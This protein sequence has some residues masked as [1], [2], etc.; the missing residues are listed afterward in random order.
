MK[1]D[2]DLQARL[3]EALK[4]AIN[5]GFNNKSTK[6]QLIENLHDITAKTV[7]DY[8]NGAVGKKA[9]SIRGFSPRMQ[10]STNHI[11]VSNDDFNTITSKL[12]PIYSAIE[13]LAESVNQ[14]RIIITLK[15]IDIYARTATSAI[16]KA[17]G[18]FM[19]SLVDAI[20]SNAKKEFKELEQ[21]GSGALKKG[22]FLE[23]FFGEMS[24]AEMQSKALD[25]APVEKFT[26]AL[27]NLIEP[28]AAAAANLVEAANK[29]TQRRQAEKVQQQR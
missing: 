29:E 18:E 19:S 20:T 10:A 26:K 25:E 12:N 16:M 28:I 27:D 21:S 17:T 24:V 1:D 11:G 13:E 22:G 14:P 4:E 6:E 9:I 7:T 23:T 3:T 15:K 8:V 5:T 2:R